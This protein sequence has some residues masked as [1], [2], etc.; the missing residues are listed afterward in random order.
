MEEHIG[1]LEWKNLGDTS[2]LR[3]DGVGASAHHIGRAWSPA[4]VYE[5]IPEAGAMYAFITIE[6]GGDV[7]YDGT[8]MDV[9]RDHLVSRDAEADIGIR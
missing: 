1:A 7:T 2:G 3:A 4:G 9:G 8:S 6:G 5:G